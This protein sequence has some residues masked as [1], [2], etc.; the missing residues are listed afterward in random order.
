[1]A[2]TRSNIEINSLRGALRRAHE[3]GAEISH[4]RRTGE[5]KIRF[6]GIGVVT[7]NARRKDASRALRALLRRAEAAG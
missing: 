2:L 7:H 4:P 6:A 5:V 3:L 1:M